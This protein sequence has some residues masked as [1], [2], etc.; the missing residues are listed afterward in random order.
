M[1]GWMAGSPWQVFSCSY[2]QRSFCLTENWLDLSS[3]DP[4]W[5]QRTPREH[6]MM[7]AGEWSFLNFEPPLMPH[8]W[9]GGAN[10]SEDGTKVR[11]W[12]CW[13]WAGCPDPGWGCGGLHSSTEPSSWL[14]TWASYFTSPNPSQTTPVPQ[15]APWVTSLVNSFEKQMHVSSSGALERPAYGGRLD[16]V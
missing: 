4:V 14:G 15:D 12:A 1:E 5:G 11:N 6:D 10:W 13:Y 8:A 7:R 3:C 16:W 9:R 2:P